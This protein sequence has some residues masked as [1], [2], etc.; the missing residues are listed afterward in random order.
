MSLKRGEDIKVFKSSL[1][2]DFEKFRNEPSVNS[3]ASLANQI[4]RHFNE[5][6]FNPEE[7]EIIYDILS[8]L[9]MDVEITI[10]RSIAQVIKDN[11]KVPTFIAKRL[12]YD[13]SEVA[14]PILKYSQ[15]LSESDLVE[16]VQSTGEVA[17]LNAIASRDY[18]PENVSNSLIEKKIDEV[19]DTLLNNKDAV[20]TH[21][22]RELIF[23]AFSQSGS[24]LETMVKR[25]GLSPELASKIVS[26]VS[27][28]VAES[29]VTEYNIS[30]DIASEAAQHAEEMIN[31]DMIGS[32]LSEKQ[33]LALVK[34]LHDSGKLNHSIV[35][36]ALC[37]GDINFFYAGLTMLANISY[38]NTIKLVKANDENAFNSLFK[39]ASMP[40]TMCKASYL[41]LQTIKDFPQGSLSPRSY[42]TKLI[43]KITALRYDKTVPNMR[44]FLA[45]ISNLK[46]N[47]SA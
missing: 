33:T 41:L 37:R 44:Y 20:I 18:V 26:F 34:H 25:G 28:N 15:A 23:E 3:R 14:T 16:I 6:N 9:T 27:Q 46:D 22:S 7:L 42:Y 1:L 39:A 10:R 38:E 24:V 5:I 11:P 21:K 40:T 19:V 30:T 4:C 12:A 43:N 36:R 31:V 2:S 29:L 35:L 17:K 13:V 8:F 47:S 45:L 32:Q